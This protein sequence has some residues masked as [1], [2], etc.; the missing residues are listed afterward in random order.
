[1][2]LL[3]TR[4]HLDVHPF[5]LGMWIASLCSPPV[6]NKFAWSLVRLH[7]CYALGVSIANTWVRFSSYTKGDIRRSQFG[8]PRTSDNFLIW[9]IKTHHD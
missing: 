9:Y 7:K 1:M 2:N 8:L 3:N 6:H 5:L 4:V